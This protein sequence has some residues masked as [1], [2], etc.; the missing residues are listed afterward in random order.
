MPLTNSVS[1]N[2]RELHHANKSKKKKRSKAEIVAI[3][4]RAAEGKKEEK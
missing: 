4:I 1:K 3:A 2:I